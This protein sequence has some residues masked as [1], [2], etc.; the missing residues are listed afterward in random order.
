MSNKPYKD[1]EPQWITTPPVEK[2][3]RSVMKW[4][5]PAAYKRPK[6]GLYKLIKKQFNLTDDDFKE[7]VDVGNE[8]VDIKVP[9][10]LTAA[11]LKELAEIVG[12]DNVTTD[13][14]KRVQV[15]YGKTMIDI[16]R[17]RKGIVE[18]LPDVVVYPSTTEDMEKL[19]EFAK[20]HGVHIYVYAGGSSVT[21]GTECMV[22]PNMILDLRKNF[23]KVIAFNEVN[24]TITVQPGISGPDLEKILN[25][26]PENFGAAHRLTC[27][28]FPQ[29]F[30]YS[31]VGG[32]VVTRG[33]GQNSTYY[34]C[35][36]DLVLCQEYVTPVG[37][38]RT[39]SAP[40]KATGPNIDQIMMGSEGTF[41][42]LTEVTLKVFKLSAKHRKFSYMFPTWEDGM[43]AMREVMQGEFGYPS[44]FRLSDA[45][46]TDM[47]MHM[48]GIAD[49]PL[50][51]LLSA[52]GFKPSQR[53]LMLG[54][55]DGEDGLQ[56]NI[57]KNIRRIAHKYNAM[58]LTGYV[59]T[60]WEHGRFSDPYMRDTIQ[61]YGIIIDT[62]ECAVN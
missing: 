62:L 26:A 11:Q 61:D 37:K 30:E 28:H 6:E 40:R 17:L 46:E 2:S 19:V 52:K 58:S 18:N 49:S 3:Y 23:N 20:K 14:F 31:C 22:A 4:G 5:D 44:V 29:S 13:E 35:A 57:V 8:V 12:E 38:I 51:A 59:T 33:S 42:I 16:M 27:G 54:F 32:W 47:M 10:R 1:F 39:D 36:A 60:S 15:G 43:A 25:N 9:S 41:G 50:N 21:R 48:Y 45:E 56:K 7:M 34:G 24:Q 53:C 55:A